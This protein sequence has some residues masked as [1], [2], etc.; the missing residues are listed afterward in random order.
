MNIP[1]LFAHGYALRI[2]V[3]ANNLPTLALPDVAKDITALHKVLTDPERC[4]YQADHVRIVAGTEATRQN[5]L[6]AL[7]WLQG[8]ITADGSGNATAFIYDS[9]HGWR[10]MAA[11]S[12]QYYLIPHDMRENKY[13]SCALRAEDFAEAVEAIQAQRLCVVLDCCHAGGMDIKRAAGLPD[14]FSSAAVP[15]SLFMSGQQDRMW[16][17]KVAVVA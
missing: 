1:H 8:T 7:E 5:I 2:G 14:K 3:D 16:L 11:N 17:T 10:D 12:P 15:A 4:A 6:E 13:R 9:G